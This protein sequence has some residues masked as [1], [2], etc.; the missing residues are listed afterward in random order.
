M[1]HALT[2][3]TSFD[4]DGRVVDR[5]V[6]YGRYREL[7]IS[8]LQKRSMIVDRTQAL[9]MDQKLIVK[10]EG[11]S[12]DGAESYRRRR[13]D[14]SCGGVAKGRS[15]DLCCFDKALTSALSLLAKST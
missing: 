13:R 8:R 4:I 12:M 9:V 7:V 10:G 11:R 2:D 1:A 15:L 5:W 6:D 3:I 14:P